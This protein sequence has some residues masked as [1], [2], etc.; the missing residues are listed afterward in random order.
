MTDFKIGDVVV[1]KSGSDRMTI[2]GEALTRGPHKHAYECVWGD[3]SGKI[4]REIFESDALKIYTP[5]E[6]GRTGRR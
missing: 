1:L 6:V 5:P 2:G 3:S 4:Q